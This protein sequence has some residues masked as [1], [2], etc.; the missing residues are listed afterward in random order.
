[1]G[2][3]LTRMGEVMDRWQVSVIDMGGTN[4]WVGVADVGG[5]LLNIMGLP[6]ALPGVTGRGRRPRR[7]RRSR[8][9]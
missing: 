3:G 9:V 5:P 8:K 1:M 2:R 6:G 4:W 7:C